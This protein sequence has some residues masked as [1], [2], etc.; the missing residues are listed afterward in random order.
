[1]P[2][3]V[4]SF[5]HNGYLGSQEVAPSMRETVTVWRAVST[6]TLNSPSAVMVGSSID[7]GEGGHLEV[8]ASSHADERVAPVLSGL[9]E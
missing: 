3:C 8:K 4:T 2:E 6:L 9:P 1:V 5:S 7:T